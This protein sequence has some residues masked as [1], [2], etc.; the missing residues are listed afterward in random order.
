MRKRKKK[1][2]GEHGVD[3]SWLIPYSDLLTLLL[4][5]FVVLFAMSQ[6]DAQKYEQLRRVFESEFSGGKGILEENISP[7]QPPLEPTKDEPEDEKKEEPND[8]EIE[9]NQLQA[10][11]QQINQ[12]I[13]K[14]N[15]ED[16]IGTKL[17][18]E[19]LFISIF[20]DLSFDPGS[21]AVSEKGEDIAKDLSDFLILDPPHQ[22]MINGHTDDRPMKSREFKSNWD[23]S[24][25]RAVNFMRILL[26]NEKLDPAT[27]SA[28]GYGEFRPIAPNDSIENRAKNRRVEVLILP[29]FEI[30]TE[31]E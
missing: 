14:N 4:A 1:S 16:A 11:Q 21:A 22:V 18:D 31:S 8:S 29:N 20:N 10:L 2:H 19:G 25:M 27:F 13:E 15:L 26:E 12:Q 7:V 3:E 24:V 5:L 30:D 9:L 6:I 17:T 28:K 23:L